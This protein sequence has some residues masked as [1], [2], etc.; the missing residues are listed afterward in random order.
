MSQM[1]RRRPASSTTAK[2]SQVTDPGGAAFRS[3]DARPQYTRTSATASSSSRDRFRDQNNRVEPVPRP[4]TEYPSY[5][6][7]NRFHYSGSRANSRS[8]VSAED[9]GFHRHTDAVTAL[10]LSGQGSVA[11]VH[12][13]GA[14]ADD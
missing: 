2:V 1:S 10:M 4:R 7:L 9:R 12:H 14:L 6:R 5:A 13:G 3:A 11:P 8:T